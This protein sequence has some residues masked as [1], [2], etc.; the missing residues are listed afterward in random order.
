M[1]TESG[2]QSDLDENEM[3]EIDLVEPDVSNAFGFEDV[4]EDLAQKT[5]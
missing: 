5:V 3:L 2:Y 1:K 4:N